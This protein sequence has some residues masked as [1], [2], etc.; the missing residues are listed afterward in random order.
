MGHR[1]NGSTKVVG[2]LSF[3]VN[4]AARWFINFLSSYQKW[5]LKCVCIDLH[6]SSTLLGYTDRTKCEDSKGKVWLRNS[7][8]TTTLSWHHNMSVTLTE[9]K[10]I[11]L[12]STT[13]FLY[14][15]DTNELA[16]YV[17]GISINVWHFVTFKQEL[18]A[19][20]RDKHPQYIKLSIG[21]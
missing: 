7:T 18:Y 13:L 5:F 4:H 19:Y 21:L 9:N 17:L 10:N 2:S 16:M 12:H 8:Y 3:S 15:Q 11:N 20:D 6:F 14:S 1:F